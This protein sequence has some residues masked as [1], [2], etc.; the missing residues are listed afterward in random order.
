MIAQRILELREEYQ[1]SLIGTSAKRQL[2][3]ERKVS[4]AI[5]VLGIDEHHVWMIREKSNEAVEF[6]IG[7]MSRLW[8]Q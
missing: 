5:E 2:A 1:N 4:R 7:K 3:V 8:K 6:G